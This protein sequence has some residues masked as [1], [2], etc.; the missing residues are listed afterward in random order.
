MSRCN[1]CAPWDIR[2]RRLRSNVLL[3]NW[4]RWRRKILT[5]SGAVCYRNSL[6][7]WACLISLRRRRDGA[8]LCRKAWAAVLPC[9]LHL[10]VTRHMSWKCR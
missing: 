5:S 9:T 4:L 10:A 3:T 8:S 1:G 6:D 2:T 7:I